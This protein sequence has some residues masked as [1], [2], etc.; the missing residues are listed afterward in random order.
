MQTWFKYK[1]QWHSGT[2]EAERA[3]S[4]T[5][6]CQY[7]TAVPRDQEFERLWLPLKAI[8]IKKIVLPYSYYNHTKNM[9][10]M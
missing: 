10:D 2:A 3:V 4:M 7:D 9:G 5:P 6:L 8:S 1:V